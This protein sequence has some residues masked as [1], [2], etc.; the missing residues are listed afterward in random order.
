MYHNAK[1]I[2]VENIDFIKMYK[3]LSESDKELIYALAQRLS[4][5][6]TV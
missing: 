4:K 5:V 1:N 2:E 6:K 3:N